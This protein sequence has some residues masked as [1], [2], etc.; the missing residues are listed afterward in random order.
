MSVTARSISELPLRYRTPE[1]WAPQALADPIALLSDH[2]YLERKAA[3]N[4]LELLNRWPDPDYPE[5]W[6]TSLSAVARDE[7]AHLNQVVRIIRRRGAR[8]ERLHRSTYAADLRSLVRR[9]Q[10]RDELVDRL[11]ISSL[12]EARSCERFVLLEKAC[13]DDELRELYGSLGA[14]EFGH[15]SLFLRLA[16]LVRPSDEVSRRW[17]ELLDAEADIIRR[18]KP[19]PGIHTGV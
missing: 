11:L 3:S 16:E 12:I 10:H 8:L 19:G 1:T 6:T 2:A 13:A 15:Y 7:S 14:S 17:S 5:E 18:Q 4:A 9:G